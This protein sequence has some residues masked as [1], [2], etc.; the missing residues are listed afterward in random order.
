MYNLVKELQQNAPLDGVGFQ[1]HFNAAGEGWN[2]PPSP[3]DMQAC[4]KQ[5]D[6]LGLSVNLSEM[7]VRISKVS[8]KGGSVWWYVW[9]YCR[10][11]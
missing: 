6:D 1:A 2:R 9:G 11:Y 8:M 5:Y 3:M 10:F 4:I 7:D